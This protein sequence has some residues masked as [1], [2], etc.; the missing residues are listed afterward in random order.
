M[1]HCLAPACRAV[2]YKWWF[3]SLYSTVWLW[4]CWP[5]SK[6]QPCYCGVWTT[7]SQCHLT[8]NCF[9]ETTDFR[10]TQFTKL[11]HEQYRCEI[12]NMLSLV[13][14]GFKRMQV[15]FFVAVHVHTSVRAHAQCVHLKK[16]AC[17]IYSNFCECVCLCACV[18]RGVIWQCGSEEGRGI[19]DHKKCMTADNFGLLIKIC[20]YDQSL[21]LSQAHSRDSR[22]PRLYL[23]QHE[24]SVDRMRRLLLI[25][26]LTSPLKPQ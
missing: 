2:T 26:C 20:W 4:T 19:K 24:P 21:G 5:S 10:F 13:F 1:C 17:H 18:Q 3:N 6:T 14:F 25:A 23:R 7:M 8:D 9:K 22:Q 15:F 16:W 12:L 11:N